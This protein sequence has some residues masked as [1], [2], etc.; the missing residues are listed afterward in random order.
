LEKRTFCT[1]FADG[2]ELLFIIFR[3][4]TFLGFGS[5]VMIELVVW[6]YSPGLEEAD[7]WDFLFINKL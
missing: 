7:A 2:S 6:D 3:L 4:M 5:L 1:K